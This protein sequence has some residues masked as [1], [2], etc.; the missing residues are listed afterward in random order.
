MLLCIVTR[1]R[2]RAQTAF[3][4][5]EQSRQKVVDDYL[6]ANLKGDPAAG[7]AV[8]TRVCAT[9]HQLGDLGVEIGLNLGALT[10]KTPETLLV[11]ILDPNRAFESRYASFTVATKDGRLITGLVASETADGVTRE[12]ARKARRTSFCAATSRR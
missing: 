4:H 3:S 5:L 9:C 7:K 1:K 2:G 12:V 11:S 8:F 10:E 6:P